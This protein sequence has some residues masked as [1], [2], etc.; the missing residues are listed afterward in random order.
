MTLG[1]WLQGGCVGDFGAN[2]VA[3][4]PLLVTH[5]GGFETVFGDI[6]SLIHRFID[7]LLH[8]FIDALTHVFH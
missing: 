2:G 1:G 8:W 7:L 6:A 4:R 3:L 5:R